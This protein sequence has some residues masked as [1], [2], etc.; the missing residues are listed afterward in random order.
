MYSELDYVWEKKN[1]S[2]CPTH[3]FLTRIATKNPFAASEIGVAVKRNS[4]LWQYHCKTSR[5]AKTVA[6]FGTWRYANSCFVWKI[7]SVGIY[8][9]TRGTWRPHL[10]HTFVWY[11][12]P[13]VFAYS[14]DP[15]HHSSYIF[16]KFIS[17]QGK[18]SYWP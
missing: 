1:T 10:D 15:D 14:T 9:I 16:D 4:F 2:Q 3:N 18:S 11:T 17:A 5:T 13:L 6:R 7:G 12:A 8:L